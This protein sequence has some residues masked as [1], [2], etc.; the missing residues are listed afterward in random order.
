[1]VLTLAPSPLNRP[2]RTG[3]CREMLIFFVF[4]VSPDGCDE[5]N[6]SGGWGHSAHWESHSA[7]GAGLTTTQSSCQPSKIFVST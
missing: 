7:D 5:C 6:M 3:F 2:H 1:M 4:E